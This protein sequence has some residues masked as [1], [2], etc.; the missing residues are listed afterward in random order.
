MFLRPK[1]GGSVVKLSAP[2]HVLKAQAQQLKKEKGITNT[3]ALD[4]IAK[5]EGF[6]S[7]ALLQSKKDDMFPKNYEEILDFFNPG[8]IVLIGARPSKGKT[9]FTIGLFVQ[10]IQRKIA[11]NYFFTLSEVHK[12][13]ASRIAIYDES[14]GHMNEHLGFIGVDYSNDI[15]ADYIIERTKGTISKKSVIVVDYL[16]LLDE[17]RSNPPLEEQVSKL[18]KFALDNECIVIFIS[19]LNREVEDRVQKRPLLEDVRLPNPLNL[20]FFNKIIMLHRPDENLAVVDVIFYR[21]K[22]FN[23]KVGWDKDL[24]FHSLKEN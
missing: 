7:W 24:K 21:P 18:K 20:K 10:A 22:E 15:S 9:S 19:Q 6:N 8:D 11:P 1:I 17:K 3:E 14:I 4:L 13:I 5:R 2:I 12:D 23:F 16:Q